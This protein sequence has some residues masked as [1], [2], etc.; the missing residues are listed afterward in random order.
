[1][2]LRVCDE[3]RLKD[4]IEIIEIL[5]PLAF[6][7][8]QNKSRGIIEEREF[9][10]LFFQYFKLLHSN[11]NEHEMRREFKEFTNFLRKDAGF[12]YEKGEDEVGNKLFGFMHL[13]FEEYFAAIEMICRW[14]EEE[15]NL[16]EYVFNSRWTEIIRLA[17]A[18]LRLSNSSRMG[19][20]KTTEFVK[21]I[22]NVN[23]P[24]P[25]A[26]RPL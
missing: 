10:G 17:A 16:D 26:Q 15:L 19:R 20:K 18:Q 25:E 24:F 7:I 14:E 9:E 23:D 8:H 4:K 2:K 1:M 22:L 11:A 21:N 13:T 6:E 3:S 5:A 12:F